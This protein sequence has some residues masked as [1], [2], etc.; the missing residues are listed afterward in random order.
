[1]LDLEKIINYDVFYVGAW[2]SENE[3]STFGNAQDEFD[4]RKWHETAMRYDR[5]NDKT[6][7]NPGTKP[8]FCPK[9][10]Y[11]SNGLHDGT[12]TTEKLHYAI[13]TSENCPTFGEKLG[14]S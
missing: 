13:L 12:E 14:A 5:T 1:M 9:S 11:Q 10:F 2:E 4:L 7:T 8:D 3:K 6:C